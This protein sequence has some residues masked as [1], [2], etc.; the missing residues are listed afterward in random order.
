MQQEILLE[1]IELLKTN[2]YLY[3]DKEGHITDLLNYKKEG[4][5]YIEVTEDF[6]TEFRESNKEL[7]NFKVEIGSNFKISRIV[8]EVQLGSLIKVNKTINNPEILIKVTKTSL[9]FK[10][11]IS[12]LYNTMNLTD[13]FNFYI[14]KKDN[15]NFLVSIIAIKYSNL[16]KGHK[17]RYSFNNEEEVIVTI[18]YFNSYGIVYE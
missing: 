1:P 10:L 13:I 5:D 9:S 17:I 2:F 4:Q 15:M 7:T 14:V 16:I 6:V 12:E 18:K 3:Y 8:N 11:L